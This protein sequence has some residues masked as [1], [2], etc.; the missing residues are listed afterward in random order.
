MKIK[1]SFS[2]IISL[3][4]IYTADNYTEWQKEKTVYPKEESCHPFC[5]TLYIIA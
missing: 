1:L 3:S 2:S 4:L 5:P